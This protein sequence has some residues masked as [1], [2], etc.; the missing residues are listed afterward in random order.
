MPGE[1]PTV[2]QPAGQ[3]IRVKPWDNGPTH[4]GMEAPIASRIPDGPTRTA[5][6]SVK[7]AF[8]PIRVIE[9]PDA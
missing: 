4:A 1:K 8:R 5:D 7:T 9:D 6:A 3:T 2:Q